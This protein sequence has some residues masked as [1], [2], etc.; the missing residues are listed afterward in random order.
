MSTDA[1]AK[2]S[3]D[4]HVPKHATR[5]GSKPTKAKKGWFRRYWWIFP[6]VPLVLI[7]GVLVALYVAY[8]R[9]ELPEALPPIRSTA[10]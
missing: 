4:K 8:Q 5:K 1:P 6:T 3:G 9:I 10:T 2:P 7:I